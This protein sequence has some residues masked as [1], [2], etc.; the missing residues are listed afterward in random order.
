MTLAGDIKIDGRGM[1][2][3]RTRANISNALLQLLEE[4]H[5]DPPAQQVAKRARVSVRAV[6]H[7]FDD[8]ENLYLE[9]V[10]L[11]A[12]RIMPLLA[13]ASGRRSTRSKARHIV[14]LHDD[15]YSIMAPL[16][17]GVRFST[18]ARGSRKI[19]E[20]LSQL[21]QATATHIQRSFDFELSRHTNPY[22]LTCRLQAVMSFE[23]WDHFRRVQGFSRHTTRSHILALLMTELE[24]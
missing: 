23:M 18:A 8:M 11:H 4:G 22:D 6:F 15:L 5:V 21:R 20:T 24:A 1:R 2:S 9:V 12:Q 3:Q 7:H 13:A 16:H 19:S 17:N 10:E 14:D